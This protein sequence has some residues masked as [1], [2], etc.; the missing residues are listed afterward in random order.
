MNDSASGAETRERLLVAATR[1]FAEH[2]IANASLLDITRQ[3]GQRNRGAVHYHFG[4]REGLLAGVLAQHADF[5]RERELGLLEEARQRPGDLSAAIEAVVR[6]ATELTETGWS[7][8]CYVVIVAELIAAGQVEA[9]DEVHAAVARTGG[10]EVYDVI[11]ERMPA[12]TEALRDERLALLTGFVLR[13]I[14]DRARTQD[15]EQEDGVAPRREVL[16][17]DLFV[18]NL[19]AMAAG[20]LRADVPS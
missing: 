13:T 16:E 14:S 18:R 4:S 11:R 5:L 9:D 1:A 15:A 6:P 17:T 19:V 20:M 7:G 3:A 10:Y 12:M 2:G 8:R